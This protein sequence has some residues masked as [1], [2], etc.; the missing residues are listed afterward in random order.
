MSVK[1]AFVTGGTGLLGINI[2]K[3]LLEN[4]S[5]RVV[6]LIRNPAE[7]KRAKLFNDILAFNGG[8][9]TGGFPYNRIEIV[10]GDVSLPDLGIAPHIRDRL[11]EAV[12]IVYHSAAVIKLSGGEAEVEAANVRGTEHVLDFAM[13]CKEIGRLEKVVHVSTVAVSGN[14]EGVFYEDELDVG[15]EFNNPYEKSKFEAEKLVAKFR[16]KGLNILIVRPSMVIG[17]SRSGFTNHFNIFYFQMRLLSQGVL[18]AIPLHEDAVYNLI[19]VD[20]AAKAICLISYDKNI[21]NENFHIVSSHEVAV[22]HFVE[23]ACEYLGYKKPSL[24]PINDLRPLPSAAFSGVRGKVLG[25]YYPYISSRKVLDASNALNFLHPSGFAWPRMKDALL[26]NMLDFCI[27]S[28][29]LPMK[30]E[31][32]NETRTY[33]A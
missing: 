1:C 5:A 32:A 31:V 15:Q 21:R 30:S 14:T 16:K 25:I 4:S 26:T 23:K 20:Y 13:R 22:K 2:V 9:W 6:L 12:D 8:K 28:G 18:D 11:A 17:H 24:L 3:E 33:N 29:Y 19:P 27:L 7:S 10:E